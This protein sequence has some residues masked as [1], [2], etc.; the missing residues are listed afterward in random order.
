MAGKLHMG[1]ARH[2]AYTRGNIP[3][4]A[5]KAYTE[6]FLM[7][8]EPPATPYDPRLASNLQMRGFLEWEQGYTPAFVGPFTPFVPPDPPPDPELE[9]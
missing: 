4:K 1:E 5:A 6:G 3:I 9:E 2:L 7:G 8:V